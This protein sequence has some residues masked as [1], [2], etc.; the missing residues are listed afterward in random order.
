MLRNIL[1]MLSV[2]AVAAGYSLPQQYSQIGSEKHG[3]CPKT[4]NVEDISLDKITGVW[5][6]QYQS[7]HFLHEPQSSCSTTEI[8]QTGADTFEITEYGYQSE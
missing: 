5:Y 1:I 4:T 7:Q 6:T 3:Q 8:D 2:L